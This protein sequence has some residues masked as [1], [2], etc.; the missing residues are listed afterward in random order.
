MTQNNRATGN[1]NEVLACNYLINNGLK[2]IERNFRCHQGEI[3]II[4][5]ECDGTIV[6]TEVK[7]RKNIK[8]GLPEE[9]VTYSKQRTI[10]KVALFY[11]LNKKLPMDGSFRFDVISILGEEEKKITWYKNAFLFIHP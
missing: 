5:K 6:F 4:A 8:K 9:A 3:D 10:S 1:E 11:L 7:Y 2:I